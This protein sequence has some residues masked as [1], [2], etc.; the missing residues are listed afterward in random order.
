MACCS[1]LSRSDSAWGCSIPVKKAQVASPVEWDLDYS[2][3]CCEQT[4]TCHRSSVARPHI[5]C[6]LKT[7]HSRG[8]LIIAV[9]LP[10][11]LSLAHSAPHSRGNTVKPTRAHSKDNTVKLSWTS[12]SYYLCWIYIINIY[13]F[14]I[15]YNI[16]PYHKYCI[17]I[18]HL[19]ATPPV[20]HNRTVHI[21]WLVDSY[22]THKSKRWLNSNPQTTGWKLYAFFSRKLYYVC[23]SFSH[24]SVDFFFFLFMLC[25]EIHYNKDF[26]SYSSYYP[27]GLHPGL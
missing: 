20:R 14:V 27:S 3:L 2:H 9:E 7:S 12:H 13:V 10:L 23:N 24:C 25:C 19:V 26:Y 21:P 16:T 1:S 8:I 5:L 4:D 11:V 6:V 22:D 18:H 15:S 17:L